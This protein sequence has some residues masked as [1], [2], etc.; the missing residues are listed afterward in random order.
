[1]VRRVRE[2]F[3]KRAGGLESA[4]A[5]VLGPYIRWEDQLLQ[6]HP[7][8]LRDEGNLMAARKK[9]VPERDAL[10]LWWRGLIYLYYRKIYSVKAATLNLNAVA[11]KTGTASPPATS[12]SSLKT[13]RSL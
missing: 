7:R 9:K 1:M 3:V 8:I 5:G 10:A 4:A 12:S 11:A 13:G 2:R 6:R